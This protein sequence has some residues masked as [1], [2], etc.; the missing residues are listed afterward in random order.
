MAVHMS[1]LYILDLFICEFAVILFMWYA[2]Y[3]LL[4]HCIWINMILGPKVLARLVE[5]RRW[6]ERLDRSFRPYPFC[7]ICRFW[8]RPPWPE[9][10]GKTGILVTKKWGNHMESTQDIRCIRPRKEPLW[11]WF[12]PKHFSALAIIIIAQTARILC[13]VAASPAP[14][15]VGCC[16]VALKICLN[17]GWKCWMPAWQTPNAS[18]VVSINIQD[19]TCLNDT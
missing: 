3:F 8:S 2:T 18:L 13:V 16:K 12:C 9:K 6:H 1:S 19:E 14:T 4:G 10:M 5:V 17:D 11:P 15:F 7:R